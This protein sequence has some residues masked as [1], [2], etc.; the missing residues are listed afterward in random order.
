[1]ACVMCNVN[2]ENCITVLELRGVTTLENSYTYKVQRGGRP[3]ARTRSA[4]GSPEHDSLRA[5]NVL[6]NLKTVLLHQKE[7]KAVEA[8]REE[9]HAP[10]HAPERRSHAEAGTHSQMKL[11]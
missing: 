1:M 4:N 7:V 9:R 3:A 11:K 5:G 6:P 10:H 2:C 8:K